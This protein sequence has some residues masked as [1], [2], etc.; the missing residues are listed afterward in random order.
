[1]RLGVRTGGSRF[2][3]PVTEGLA[4][5]AKVA[6]I[7][8]QQQYLESSIDSIRAEIAALFLTSLAPTLYEKLEGVVAGQFHYDWSESLAR[9]LILMR[10]LGFIEDFNPN[11]LKDRTDLAGLIIPTRQGQRF[12]RARRQL[13]R[14]SR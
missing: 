14:P 10:D 4:R 3:V 2:G 7:D 13:D 11:D 8:R 6:R 1:M 5:G 9:E 12:V